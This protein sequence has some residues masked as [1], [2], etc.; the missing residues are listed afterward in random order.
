MNLN[1]LRQVANTLYP[2]LNTHVGVE[3]VLDDKTYEVEQF[4]LQF[5]QEADHKG[6]PQHETKGGQFSIT[7]T[8]SVNYNI[9]NW[10][11]KAN[12]RKKGKILFKKKTSGTVLEIEFSNAHCISLRRKT[13]H[14]TGT[15][16]TLVIAP[17][18]ISLNG[19]THDNR[20]RE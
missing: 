20:W 9:M 4:Q 7:L 16:T 19:T 12:E 8:Q 11:K 14:Q 10:A 18:I 3:F 2:L 5:Q 13:N 1:N 17:E 15:T 6:Q